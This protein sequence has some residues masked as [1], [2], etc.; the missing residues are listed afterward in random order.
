MEKSIKR[1]RIVQLVKFFLLPKKKKNCKT[2]VAFPIEYTFQVVDAD[3]YSIRVLIKK[4]NIPYCQYDSADSC[5]YD[6][7]HIKPKELSVD[8]KYYIWKLI[9]EFGKAIDGITFLFEEDFKNV[10]TTT[11]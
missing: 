9:N 8:E 4:N 10:S 2:D 6:P 1:L 5:F 11:E 3:Y 7:N